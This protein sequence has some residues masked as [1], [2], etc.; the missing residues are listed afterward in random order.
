MVRTVLS[1]LG[2]IHLGRGHKLDRRVDFLL[3]AEGKDA[4][5]VSLA[6]D[7]GRRIHLA[8]ATNLKARLRGLHILDA[9]EG[10][11]VDL[12][13][14]GV[15]ETGVYAPLSICAGGA[16]AEFANKLGS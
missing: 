2:S 11:D 7:E 16:V 5:G 9:K 13:A 10:S 1:E 8:G 15:E 4:I 6:S 12:R 3:V 14:V